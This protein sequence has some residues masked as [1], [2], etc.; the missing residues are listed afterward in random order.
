ML[1]SIV[2]LVA[3]PAV[4]H[5]ASGLAG[6]FAS[7][8]SHPL[9]GWDHVAAMVAVG[10]LGAVLGAPAVYLLPIVFPLVMAG[11]GALGVAGVPI[12]GIEV[13]IALSAV[14]LGLLIAAGQ[15]IPLV[16]AVIVVGFFAVFHGHAHGTELPAAADALAYSVGFVVGTGLLHCAGIAIGTA[17]RW[18]AGKVAVRATGGA[19]AVA[20]I[21]F[22]T[23][24]A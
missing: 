5:D 9:F 21:A 12:P 24:A 2:V 17:T 8:I 1:A 14:V 13:G 4:A 23:G 16:M 22:L 18:E 20:G 11:G 3:A 15:R 10:L 19:I 6:G 7:G